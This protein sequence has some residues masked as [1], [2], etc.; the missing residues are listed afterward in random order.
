MKQLT[1][2]ELEAYNKTT[3]CYLCNK[4]L[5]GN[6]VMDHDHLTGKYRGPAHGGYLQLKYKGTSS[7]PSVVKKQWEDED[8]MVPVIFHNLRGYGGHLIMKGLRKCIFPNKKIKC[9][10]NNMEKYLSFTVENLRF[11]DSYHFMSESLEKLASNMK[12]DDF[13]HT[14]LQTATDKLHLLLRKGVFPYEYWDSEKRFYENQVP[15]KSAFYS[16]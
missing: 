11:I 14:A 2:E 13:I 5:D 4:L 10:L 6:N 7:T 16:K 8:Y 12:K 1:D 9:I 15:P 3:K